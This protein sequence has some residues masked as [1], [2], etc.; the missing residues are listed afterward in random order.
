MPEPAQHER[1]IVN[2]EGERVAL[3]PLSRDLLP[4]Y[5]RW[6]ND[7]TAMHTWDDPPWPVS[8]EERTAWFDRAFEATDTAHFTVY[9]RATW[10]AVGMASLDGIDF[11]H[12]TAELGLLIGEPEAR[13]RGNG[14]EATRLVADYAFHGLGLHS[15]MLRVLSY[16]LAGLPAYAKAGFREFGRWRDSW[17]FAGRRWDAVYLECRADGFASPGL[18]RVFVPDEPRTEDAPSATAATH[19]RQ[20]SHDEA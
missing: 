9:E 10:R 1:P 8:L 18:D 13:N 17:V 2:V 7:F 14:T 20:G 16:N 3:G 11:R 6:R 19:R 4:A 12:G 15:V 5:T